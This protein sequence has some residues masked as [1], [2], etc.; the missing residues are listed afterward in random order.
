MKGVILAIAPQ[1]SIVDLT[2]TVPPQDVAAGAYLLRSAAPHFP[3]GTIHVAVVDPGV[4]TA[5]RALLVETAGGYFIG[6]DNGVL[7]AAVPP[8]DV[9]RIF[10]ISRS[11]YRR[12]PVSQTFHGRD[13]FAPVA[14]HLA[15]GVPIERLGRPIRALRRTPA[16]PPRR[17]GGALHGEVIWVD[18]FGNLI[19]NVTRADLARFRRG[20]RTRGLSVRIADRA[21]RLRRSY[22]GVPR[23]AALA[24]V[25]SA[26]ALEIAVNQGSARAVLG[27]DRGAPIT[28]MAG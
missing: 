27:C 18:H 16:S 25:N 2:H 26:D 12:K 21:V 6:P 10:D 19:S 8:R 9:R 3:R 11:K 1:A 14:A 4:G 28:V 22:A 23:G 5:R 15:A 24:I 20:F 17:R 13:V 7:V